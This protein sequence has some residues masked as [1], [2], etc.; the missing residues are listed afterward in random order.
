MHLDYIQYNN[1]PLPAEPHC[2]EVNSLSPQSRWLRSIVSH[3]HPH[4]CG[5]GALDIMK[6]EH[7]P[8]LSL[9]AKQQANKPELPPNCSIYTDPKMPI[10]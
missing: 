1:N 7:P 3:E 10:P 4:S 2:M 8:F 9:I 6:T 5:T